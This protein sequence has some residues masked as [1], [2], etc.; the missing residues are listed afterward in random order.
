MRV[1]LFGVDGLTFRILNPMMERGL[2]P[3]F[4]RLRERGVEGV[5]KSTTP[6]VT[7]PAWTS[8]STGLAP[9]KHGV[10][11]FWEYEKTEHGPVA[12]V[13]THRKGGKAIWNVL[14]D[15][16]K[17]VIVANVPVTY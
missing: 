14:S 5:L 11:D 3:N 7:P 16:G 15:W 17:R 4:Q 13:V 10:F 8:I 2:L 1:F 6:P 12:H 9:A